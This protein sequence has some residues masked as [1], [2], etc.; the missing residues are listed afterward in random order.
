M[1]FIFEVII[2]LMSAILGFLFIMRVWL[3]YRYQRELWSL[4][5]KVAEKFGLKVR[6]SST[7]TSNYP[8]IYGTIDERKVYLHPAKRKRFR[9]S[10]PAKTV[11]GVEHGVRVE[12]NIII[13]RPSTKTKEEDLVDLELDKL[14]K[15]KLK[16][17][18]GS[19][20]NEEILNDMVDNT[21][22]RKIHNIIEESG[23][24]FRAMIIEP[25]LLM[26]STF[27][28]E[29]DEDLIDEYIQ[30]MYEIAVKMEDN[31]GE[32]ED[33][34]SERFAQLDERNFALPL[35]YIIDITLALLGVYM[36]ISSL[37]SMS[38]IYINVGIVILSVAMVMLITLT[39]LVI[40]GRR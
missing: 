38:F 9:K 26:F 13:T 17:K 4:F 36:I 18:S 24:N 3:S 29:Q 14:T 19:K 12:D 8:D 1:S 15:Y 34:F 5:S 16:I 31:I 28:F 6:H 35:K 33:V 30:E 32:V 7:I 21:V 27:G 20:L 39:S 25:G 11:I 22:A 40:K 10:R 23:D 2:I 37:D